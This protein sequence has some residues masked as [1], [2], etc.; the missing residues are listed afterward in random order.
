MYQN[1]TKY[2]IR[3]EKTQVVVWTQVVGLKY[4]CHIFFCIFSILNQMLHKSFMMP[5]SQIIP[6]AIFKYLN[7]S[8][9]INKITVDKRDLY[10]FLAQI[11]HLSYIKENHLPSLF[12]WPIWTA[13]VQKKLYAHKFN[14]YK[15]RIGSPMNR[16]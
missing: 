4:V 7:V 14:T 12:R 2:C 3:G 5:S 15:S 8:F 1:G 10:P 16:A 9:S 11:R 13:F 6:V